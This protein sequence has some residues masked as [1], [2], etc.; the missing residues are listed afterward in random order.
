MSEDTNNPVE[1]TAA[2]V[3]SIDSIIQGKKEELVKTA[4]S[5]L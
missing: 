4:I 3:P 5:N 1:K 2:E